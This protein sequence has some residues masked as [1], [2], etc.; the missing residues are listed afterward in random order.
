MGYFSNLLGEQK[1]MQDVKLDQL[2]S[3]GKQYSLGKNIKPEEPTVEFKELEYA[4]KTDS[5]NFNAINKS[6]QMIMA[7]GFDR[8]DDIKKGVVKK[9]DKFFENIGE[10]GQDTTFEELFESIFRDEMI[11]GNAYVEMIFNEQETKVID[12]AII[13]PKKIDYAKT[14]DGKIILDRMGKPIGYIIQFGQGTYAEG[15]S[16]PEPYDKYVNIKNNSIFVLNKRI[17]HFKLYPIGDKFYGIGL[18]E[19]SYKSVIYKKNIEKGQANSI[20]MKG[21][22]P[23]IGYVGND[24]RMATPKDME[25]VLEKMKKIDSLKCGVFP[26]WVNIKPI[27]MNSTDLAQSA[28]KDMRMDQIASLSTPQSLVSGS[29][30][31]TN[32]STLATQKALWEFTL[33]DIIKQTISHFRKYILKTID[34]YN[35]YGGVPTIKWGELKAED[36]S[37]TIGNVIRLLTSKSSNI[38]PEY[39]LDLEEQLRKLMDT[40]KSGKKPKVIIPEKKDIKDMKENLSKININLSNNFEKLKQLEK[41]K[42]KLEENHKQEVSSMNEMTK[43]EKSK[44]EKEIY[45]KNK[46]VEEKIGKLIKNVDGKLDERDKLINDSKDVISSLKNVGGL[47]E[48][49]IHKLKNE[50]ETLKERE[51]RTEKLIKNKEIDIL[52]RKDEILN[53]LKEDL[54]K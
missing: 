11:Y 38:T 17:C 39:A 18:L 12:L 1:L 7:G 9:F 53:K 35:G 25:N 40:K 30:E 46:E 15:D 43:L 52:T 6:V 48:D 14:S 41:E 49:I 29:G 3:S 16:I 22:N 31:T 10:I 8:F 20:Y 5:I 42:I 54:E 24:R 36:L 28:L 45:E 50:I 2:S 27:E 32:R 47:K 34:K 44:K 13:D 26:D 21:F 33:K 51:V 23:L 37:E 4:Y 19:P